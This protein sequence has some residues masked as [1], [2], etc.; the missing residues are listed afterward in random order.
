MDITG[1]KAGPASERPLLPPMRDR[2]ASTSSSVG[3]GPAVATAGGAV[4]AGV[5]HAIVATTSAHP[6]GL[7]LVPC[8]SSGKASA[9]LFASIP[10]AE[11]NEASRGDRGNEDPISQR[12]CEP[13]CCV[14]TREEKRE[15]NTA[16]RHCAG[17]GCKLRA[18]KRRGD[19]QADYQPV[20]QRK[21]IARVFVKVNSSS[22][23]KPGQEHG[24]RDADSSD[25]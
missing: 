12:N 14:D 19:S 5:C 6:F 15:P 11:P 24:R 8:C 4:V 1:G 2:F 20:N 22:G 18:K 21:R 25:P 10:S 16:K 17:N 23:R 7:L 13:F 3:E 9:V